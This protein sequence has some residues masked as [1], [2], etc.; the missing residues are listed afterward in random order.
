MTSRPIALV[1]GSSRGIGADIAIALARDGFS[2]A[3]NYVRDADAAARVVNSIRESGGMAEA[4]QADIADAAQAAGLVA[5]VVANLGG[6]HCLVNNAGVYAG[7]ALEESDPALVERLFATNVFGPIALTRAAI[8]HL[9]A[10]AASGPAGV[11]SVINITSVAAR[12]EWTGGSVYCASKAAAEAL[13]RCHAAELGPKGIRVNAV[14]PGVT[15][16][17]INRA[18]LTPEFRAKVSASTALGR[19]GSV[20]DIAPLVVFLASS[21]AAWITGQVIDVD[22]G[23]RA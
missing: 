12:A 16:T 11:A 10:S 9:A 19:V 6:L 2:L 14:A 5:A 23:Y 17:D 22:G 4:F 18:G 8:P 3:V 21:R 20:G 15:E 1:T 7:G 13:T